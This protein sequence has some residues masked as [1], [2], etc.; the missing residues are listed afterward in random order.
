MADIAVLIVDT[1]GRARYVASWSKDFGFNDGFDDT[2][3]HDGFDDTYRRT[4]YFSV[5]FR[6]QFD[7]FLQ[8]NSAV[9]A[10]EL[11]ALKAYQL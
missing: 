8:N 1:I 2:L 11:L 6:R 3:V 7:L 4:R 9:L 5:H 10:K